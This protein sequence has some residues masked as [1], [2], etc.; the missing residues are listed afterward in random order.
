LNNAVSVAEEKA[1]TAQ[2]RLRSLKTAIAEGKA[3]I[4]AKHA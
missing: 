2:T 1:M 3:A 4:R